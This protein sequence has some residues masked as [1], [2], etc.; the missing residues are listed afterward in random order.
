VRVGGYEALTRR[1][2]ESAGVVILTGLLRSAV[3]VLAR[4]P[5]RAAR[6][7]PAMYALRLLDTPK[8][9][10]YAMMLLCFPER[11]LVIH[12]LCMISHEPPVKTPDP[13][14]EAYK[15]D[16][17]RTLVRENLKLSPEQRI[18][19]LIE[20]QRFAEELGRAGTQAR[21]RNS[22]DGLSGPA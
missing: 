22:D 6:G 8:S 9:C 18:L 5:G 1:R 14:I 11:F 20:L 17:D 3:L 21:D 7:K 4:I 19:K 15:Q 2:Q 16:V 10:V 12:R 13:V